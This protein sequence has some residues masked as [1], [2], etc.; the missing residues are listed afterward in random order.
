[1]REIL[2]KEASHQEKVLLPKVVKLKFT[3]ISTSSC[4]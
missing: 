1:M 2:E 4:P 3:T